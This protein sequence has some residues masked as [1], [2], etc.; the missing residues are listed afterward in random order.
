MEFQALIEQ[1]YSVRAYKPDDVVRETMINVMYGLWN[2]GF[3]KQMWVNNHGQLWILESAIQ[4][5]C[6][7]YQ[8]PGI[9]RVIDW[10]RA[11]REFFIPVDREDSLTT[12]FIHADEAEAS[13]A[14]L[15]F[16]EMLM[17]Q[18]HLYLQHTS[19]PA[20]QGRV[21]EQLKPLPHQHE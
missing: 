6:K 14:Q 17:R 20:S 16:P 12:D 3:R 11:I 19:Y 13:V 8:L 9:Y 21:I 7:R 18:K 2:D 10:H 4:E 5:F 1:R 15:L